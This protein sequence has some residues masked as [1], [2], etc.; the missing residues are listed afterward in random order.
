MGFMVGQAPELKTIE[1]SVNTS[2]SQVI[3]P[4]VKS[5]LM[6]AFARMKTKQP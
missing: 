3:T 1:I 5:N 4:T 6:M 2:A